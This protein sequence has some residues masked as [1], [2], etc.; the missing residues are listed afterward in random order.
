[1]PE[2]HVNGQRVTGSNRTFAQSALRFNGSLVDEH[3]AAPKPIIGFFALNLCR[4]KSE[5]LSPEQAKKPPRDVSGVRLGRLARAKEFKG[6]GVGEILLIA[7]MEKF[8]EIFNIAGG[9]GLFVDA[10]DQ[11][12]KE[13]Y[14]KFGFVSLP[15]NASELFLPIKTIQ[16]ALARKS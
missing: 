13:F 4:I 16:Q 12:A 3:A 14:E 11:K 2:S 15:S 7:A 9:I 10:K 6:R 8:I 1:L 5:T